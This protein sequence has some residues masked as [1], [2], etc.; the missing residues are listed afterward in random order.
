MDLRI[1]GRNNQEKLWFSKELICQFKFHYDDLKSNYMI[2]LTWLWVDAVVNDLRI[3]IFKTARISCKAICSCKSAAC[4]STTSNNVMECDVYSK[5]KRW[6]KKQMNVSLIRKEM[7][8][9]QGNVRVYENLRL[10][11]THCPGKASVFCAHWMI[12]VKGT[13]SSP[14]HGN[15]FSSWAWHL[16]RAIWSVTWMFTIVGHITL[17][18]NVVGIQF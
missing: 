16:G 14:G 12:S 1:E 3:V 17:A 7:N 4:F 13:I 8:S 18:Q 9:L 11:A 15:H 2:K 6:I 10:S 5:M